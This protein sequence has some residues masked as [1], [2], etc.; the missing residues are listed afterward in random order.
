MLGVM[1]H[2][3]HDV[4][5][6]DAVLHAAHSHLAHAQVLADVGRVGVAL[7]HV[8]VTLVRGQ[9]RVDEAQ[10]RRAHAEG[11]GDATLVRA[12]AAHARRHLGRRHA[13]ARRV[14]G[15]CCEW[16]CRLVLRVGLQAG[17]ASGVADWCCEWGCRLVLRVGFAGGGPL[18]GGHRARLDL[19]DELGDGLLAEDEQVYL[20]H[21][22]H[23]HLLQP[24]AGAR[25]GDH[26]DPVVGAR[27][28]PF[29]LQLLGQLVA[30]LVRGGGQRAKGV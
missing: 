19:A 22:D 2:A 16:G 6:H 9:V 14:A 10:V 21:R 15:R 13:R 20:P 25:F 28:V 8:V 3:T 26:C 29:L 30:R 5:L 7:A 4:Q 24:P 23:A 17:A 27:L 18:V 12:H 11:D 1:H